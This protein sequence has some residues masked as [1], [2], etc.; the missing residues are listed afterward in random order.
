MLSAVYL[1]PNW[2]AISMLIVA[3]V[4]FGYILYV[5]FSKYGKVLKKDKPNVDTT[6][7]TITPNQ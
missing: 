2:T 6:P 7:K 1:W 4:D 5:I 3:F